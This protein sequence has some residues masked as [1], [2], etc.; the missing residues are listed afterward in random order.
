MLSGAK[1]DVNA[2]DEVGR[3]IL[4]ECFLCVYACVN[5]PQYILSD[6]MNGSYNGRHCQ[7]VM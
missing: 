6:Y 4:G 7:V 3:H 5:S 2:K 1:A